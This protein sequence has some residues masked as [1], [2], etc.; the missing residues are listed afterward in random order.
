MP[1]GRPLPETPLCTLEASLVAYS[2]VLMLGHND[3]VTEMAH[4]QRVA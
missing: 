4:V 1:D 3:P 2:T